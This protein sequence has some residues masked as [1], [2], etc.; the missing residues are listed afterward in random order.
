MAR[1]L[2]DGELTPDMVAITFDDAYRDVLEHAKPVVDAL[3][4]PATVF[5]VTDK[6][7]D[8]RGFWWDRLAVAVLGGTLPQSM[9]PLSL[10]HEE[11]NEDIASAFAD[12]DRQRLH[13]ALWRNIRLLPPEARESAVDEVERLFAPVPHDPAPI[14]TA[15]ELHALTA[16]GW[17]S[18]GA[19]TATHPSLPSLT[20][21]GQR[22]EIYRSKARLEEITGTPMS[23]L[24]YPF[25]DYDEQ[26]LTIARELGFDHA[27]SVETG[28]VR[29]PASLFRLPRHDI[30]NWNG[31]KFARRVRWR[32]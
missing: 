18:L 1:A 32:F 2:R 19:H 9:I 10:L 29:D 5:V 14:M 16:S 6:L 26:S 21:E 20:N 17:V 3:E 24:A 22:D 8:P 23:R 13:L 4:I 30:K 25:G 27:V 15:D 7:G 31:D 12:G 11:E 28:P